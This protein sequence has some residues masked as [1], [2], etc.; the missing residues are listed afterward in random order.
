[1]GRL[2]FYSHNSLPCFFFPP[3]VISPVCC[4][5]VHCLHTVSRPTSLSLCLEKQVNENNKIALHTSI[6]LQQASSI[7]KQPDR[8][9]KDKMA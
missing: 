9:R 7:Y 2:T 1:M 5:S 8:I 3:S 4:C 6:L